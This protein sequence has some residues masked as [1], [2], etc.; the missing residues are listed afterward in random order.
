MRNEI[1]MN[2]AN[3]TD[4]KNSIA[5][6]GTMLKHLLEEFL[7]VESVS[8]AVVVGRDG[9]VIESAVSGEVDLEALGAMASTG[10]GTSET[11]GL[12][13]EKGDLY[14]MLVELQKGPVLLS[15]LSSDELIA[16][17]ADGSSHIG[18][19]RYELKKNR[20]RIIAAL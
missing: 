19:I 14:Q 2:R 13:L 11:M 8:A 20:E 4:E 6:D 10:L 9:F 16:I 5:R 17:V 15:P 7:K 1:Q 18:R 3:G 12:T